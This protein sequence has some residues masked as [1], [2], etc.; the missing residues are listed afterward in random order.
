MGLLRLAIWDF[1]LCLVFWYI[2]KRKAVSSS[3]YIREG[4]LSILEDIKK[5]NVSSWEYIKNESVE[6]KV[7]GIRSLL[8]FLGDRKKKCGNSSGYIR[9]RWLL[10]FQKTEKK[11]N[12]VNSSEN[13]KRM[14]PLKLNIWDFSI[15]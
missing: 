7:L 10:V 8:T 15:F 1:T 5:G 6:V 14:C 9:R 13:I 3:G 11:R 2:E 12:I 4:W